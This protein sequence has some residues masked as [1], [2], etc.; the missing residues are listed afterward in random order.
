MVAIIGTINRSNLNNP[1]NY[2]IAELITLDTRRHW[3]VFTPG[4]AV[5]PNKDRSVRSF[6]A[7]Y[8]HRI[9]L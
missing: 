7:L 6:A 3:F 9:G 8:A 1:V 4:R 5:F 2:A